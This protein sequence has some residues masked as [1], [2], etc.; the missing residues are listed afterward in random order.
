MTYYTL[1]VKWTETGKYSPE[2][3]SYQCGEVAEEIYYYE[4]RDDVLALVIVA[5]P[6][7]V[8]P[9]KM[10]THELDRL[11]LH[12]EQNEEPRAQIFHCR[13]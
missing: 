4:D 1:M 7:T 10:L 13:Y 6:E 5:H 9:S 8:D 12:G 11:S 2:F 3:G